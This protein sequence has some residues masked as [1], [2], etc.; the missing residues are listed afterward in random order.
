MGADTVHVGT[1]EASGIDAESLQTCH[2]GL[3]H[4]STIHHCHHLQHLCIGDAA[5]VHH[6]CLNA[7]L[8]SDGCCPATA[9]VHENLPSFNVT[10]VA[11]QLTELRLVLNDGTADLDDEETL[12][13]PLLVRKGSR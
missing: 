7:Q 2:D 4:Q 8:R 9:A 13:L 5:S 10:E 12:P 6:L 3:V 1:S 11:Q